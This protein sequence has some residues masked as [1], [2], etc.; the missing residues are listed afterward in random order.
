MLRQQGKQKH[1]EFSN[2]NIL[3]E[4]WQIFKCW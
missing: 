2:R 1:A 3:Q 4:T